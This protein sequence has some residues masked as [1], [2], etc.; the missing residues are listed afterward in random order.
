VIKRVK[1]F[2]IL[3]IAASLGLVVGLYAQSTVGAKLTRFSEERAEITK[4]DVILLNTRIAVLQEMLKDDLSVPLVPTSITYDA[5]N[6]KIPTSV[7]VDPSFLSKANVSQLS[8]TLDSRATSLCIAPSMAE[9]N[10]P[11]VFS[12]APKEY[13]VIRFFTHTLDSSGH[14]QVK[15]LGQFE[16]GK[17]SLK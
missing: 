7:F 12:L 2:L 13:C 16:D 14:I 15:E 3:S 1:Q 9:G 4:M 5:E 11:T 17:L 10:L 8:K 6:R